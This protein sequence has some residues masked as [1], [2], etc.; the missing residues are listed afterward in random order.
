M[1]K[2]LGYDNANYFPDYAKAIAAAR[3]EV[4]PDNQTLLAGAPQ[5]FFITLKAGF[6]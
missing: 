4:A 6:S 1:I 5:Q 3:G 2:R